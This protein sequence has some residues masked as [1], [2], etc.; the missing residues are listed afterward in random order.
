VRLHVSSFTFH[1]NRLVFL[2]APLCLW[3]LCDSWSCCA[4]AVAV[5]FALYPIGLG[6]FVFLCAP[7]CPLWFKELAGGPPVVDRNVVILTREGCPHPSRFSTG[8]FRNLPN[9]VTASRPGSSSSKNGSC[10]IWQVADSSA[11]KV[12]SELH[13]FGSPA[14]RSLTIVR[15]AP[16]FSAHLRTGT[17]CPQR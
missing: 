7:L 11:I 5:G 14:R 17:L 13:S 16:E 2:Y 3:C 4:L 1:A 8:G 9:L 12:C 10:S 15:I 6:F